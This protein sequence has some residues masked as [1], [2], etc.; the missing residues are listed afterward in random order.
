[1]AC[2]A[3]TAAD[4]YRLIVALNSSIWSSS[5]I[6]HAARK[7]GFHVCMQSIGTRIAD[8]SARIEE[9]AKLHGMEAQPSAAEEPSAQGR[10]SPA[11]NGGKPRRKGSS[12]SSSLSKEA[13]S[14]A[15]LQR[16][17]SRGER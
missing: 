7:S 13:A 11:S 3:L 12:S 17:L 5:E 9:T 14:A 8:L 15:K 4:F 16:R 1:M 2:R 6:A 10:A